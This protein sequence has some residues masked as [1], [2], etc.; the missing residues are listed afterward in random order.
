[1][2]EPNVERPDMSNYGVPSE[3]DGTL[4]WSWA[5]ER[6]VASRNYWVVTASA[7]S[8]PHAMPVWGVWSA[9]QNTF[10]FSCDPSARKARNLAVNPQM[11]VTAESTVEVVSIEGQ[12]RTATPSEVDAAVVAYIGKY[13]H[14]MGEMTE[15]DVNEFLRAHASYTM[16]PDRGF[17]IIERPE[18]FAARA[19]RW[20]WTMAA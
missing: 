17:G 7:D 9:E 16:E 11:T 2:S 12:A 8:R 20:R 18:D 14:E 1:M 10:W 15:A 13:L 6:L 3:L 5:R 19:T 4:P